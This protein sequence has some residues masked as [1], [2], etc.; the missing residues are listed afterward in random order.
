MHTSEINDVE[1]ILIK[2]FFLNNSFISIFSNVILVYYLPS[3]S[4][5]QLKVP[6]KL[7]KIKTGLILEFAGFFKKVLY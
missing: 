4:L 1:I 5:K 2:L 7:T 3:L 6:T